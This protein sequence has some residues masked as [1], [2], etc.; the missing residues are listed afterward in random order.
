MYMRFGDLRE[1][2]HLLRIGNEDRFAPTLALCVELVDGLAALETR[3]ERRQGASKCLAM[4]IRCTSLVP[5][6]ISQI[7]ASR[8][9]RSTVNSRV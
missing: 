6:P 8:K 3:E 5:S 2:R 4:T 9:W 7:L 1:V